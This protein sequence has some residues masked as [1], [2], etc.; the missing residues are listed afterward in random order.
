MAY[1]RAKQ[2]AGVLLVAGIAIP[3]AAHAAHERDAQLRAA[4]DLDAMSSMVSQVEI[5]AGGGSEQRVTVNGAPMVFEKHTEQGSLAEVMG[6]I[7][8]QC[9]SGTE[10]AAF[11]VT[12]ATDDGTS[13]PIKLERVFSQGEGDV[14]ASLCIFQNDHEGAEARDELK[15]VRYT[16]AYKRDDGSIG[17]TTV[18]NA[19]S[20]PLQ[21]MFPAEGDA[22]GNDIPGLPRPEAARRTLTATVGTH[23]TVRVYESTLDMKGSIES[24]DKAMEILGFAT[25]GTLDD[26]RMYRKDGKSYAASFRGT[27]GGST[28]ALVPFSG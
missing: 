18:V 21:E 6:R 7:A 10:N 4:R 3:A 28:I 27:T 2:V 12:K 1:A 16:L 22:P 11:G 9:D 5:A 24:Y 8:K 25:T 14:R 26:A 13:K 15:R 23:Q 19:S 20:T 17:V